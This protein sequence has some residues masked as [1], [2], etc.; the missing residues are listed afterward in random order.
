MKHLEELLARYP[1]LVPCR[2]DIESAYRALVE[3][4]AAGGKLLVCGNG[5]SAADSAKPQ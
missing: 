4:Y 1:A 5:G 2:A 3:C